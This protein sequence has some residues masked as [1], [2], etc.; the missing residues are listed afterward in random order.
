MIKL[1][2]SPITLPA[3]ESE[4]IVVVTDSLIE[5]AKELELPWDFTDDDYIDAYCL[6]VKDKVYI[7]YKDS[8]NLRTVLHEPIHAINKIY[9]KIGADI[10]TDNDETYVRDVCWLQEEVI[11]LV[12]NEI[13]LEI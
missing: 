4:V 11:K 10:H 3:Y 6:P 12:K 13:R 1:K 7:V 8:V 5:T 9:N 2:S